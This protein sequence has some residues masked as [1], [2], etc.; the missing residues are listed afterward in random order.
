MNA[1]LQLT[2]KI[3]EEIMK[4]F[5]SMLAVLALVGGGC[6]AT[7]VI[8]EMEDALDHIEDA[9]ESEPSE[10]EDNDDA[11][12]TSAEVSNGQTVQT[13]DDPVADMIIETTPSE[14][15]EQVTTETREDGVVEIVLGGSATQDVSMESGNF[16][17]TPDTIN[18][19][20]GEKVSVTFTAN[21]GFHTFVIDEIGAKFSI[22]EGE[23]FT[24]TA[25]EEPGSYAYYCDIG[26]HRAFGMEGVLIV[27]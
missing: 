4:Y 26:S 23:T 25:P 8:P 15:T 10:D 6:V 12:D 20:P 27:Q 18:A 24:F 7:E 17:F 14:I 19:A 2:L 1:K 9:M 11:D 16:F 21:A 13:S 5:L 3:K 22:S